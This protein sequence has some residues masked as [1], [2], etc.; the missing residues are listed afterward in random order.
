MRKPIAAPAIAPERLTMP[1]APIARPIERFTPSARASATGEGG[2]A[3]SAG[4]QCRE[5]SYSTSAVGK[6]ATTLS[7]RPDGTD[8]R[9]AK[10]A[11]PRNRTSTVSGA[12]TLATTKENTATDAAQETAQSAKSPTQ[13]L[14]GFHG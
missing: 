1:R 7:S 13:V 10:S 8:S 12:G 14:S 4:G 11:E 9:N 3:A 5:R 6:A 2:A